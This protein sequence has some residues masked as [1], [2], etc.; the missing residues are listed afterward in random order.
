M[1]RSWW[2]V[3]SEERNGMLW[4]DDYGV[5]NVGRLII[6]LNNL[7]GFAHN[8]GHEYNPHTIHNSFCWDE[9]NDENSGAETNVLNILCAF[10]LMVI[11]KVHGVWMCYHAYS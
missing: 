5:K 9:V 10:K 3:D 11:C 2:N 7:I 8:I 6:C 1:M 4:E